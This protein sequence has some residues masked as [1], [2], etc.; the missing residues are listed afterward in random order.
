[1]NNNL[2]FTNR[3]SRNIKRIVTSESFS[4]MGSD[5]IFEFLLHEMEIVSF[6]DY[7]KRC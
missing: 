3:A 1:M 5:M 7:L 6:K 4:D 2:D